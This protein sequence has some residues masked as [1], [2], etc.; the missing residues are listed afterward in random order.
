LGNLKYQ[1]GCPLNSA[2]LARGS[3]G[4]DKLRTVLV[5]SASGYSHPHVV[6]LSWLD[7]TAL[8]WGIPWLH[9][10]GSCSSS[11][12]KREACPLC[13]SLR[14]RIMSLIQKL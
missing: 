6:E 11:P 8:R 4:V 9:V 13:V 3:V 12:L 1:T 7:K 10:E 5:K 2:T 14:V